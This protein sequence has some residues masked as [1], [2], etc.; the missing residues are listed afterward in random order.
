MDQP[1]KKLMHRGEDDN[2]ESVSGA[3]YS[4]QQQFQRRVDAGALPTGIKG[5]IDAA[6]Q[7]EVTEQYDQNLSKFLQ[8]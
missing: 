6:F 3:E 4:G 8:H 1:N 7:N 2:D 5:K